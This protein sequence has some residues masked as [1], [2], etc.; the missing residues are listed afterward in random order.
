MQHAVAPDVNVSR[1]DAVQ[2]HLCELVARFLSKELNVFSRPDSTVIRLLAASPL[3]PVVT[4]VTGHLPQ[5]LKR[6][7]QFRFVFAERGML[8]ARV[9]LLSALNQADDGLAAQPGVLMR[10]SGAA[11]RRVHE[12]LILGDRLAW[13]GAPMPDKW[14]V[15]SNM[16]QM[17]ERRNAVRMAAMGFDAV[18]IGADE[19]LN[20]ADIVTLPAAPT[21]SGKSVRLAADR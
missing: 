10:I 7:C 17:I 9:Q 1:H 11:A 3:S 20:S 6:D 2:Q 16:G 13:I 4:A 8:D 5:L 12:S 19:L 21:L 14:A 18:R 15:E